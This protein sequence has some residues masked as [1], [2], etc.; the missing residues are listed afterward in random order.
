[1]DVAHKNGVKV[2]GTVFFAP[3]VYGGTQAA[4]QSFLQQDAG[5]NFL[6]AAKM[7]EIANY[8]N[9]DGW[10]MNCE[11]AVNS[12]TGAKMASFMNKLDS[13]YTGELIWYDALLQNGN[14][15]Y[16]NRLNANNAYFFQHSTGLFTNYA[17]TLASTVSSS[18]NYANGLALSPYRVYTGADMWPSRT[19]Q[20]AFTNYTWI[21]KIFNNGI[22][23]TS[24]A[25]FATNFTYN[26]SGFSNFNNDSTDFNNFY[27]AEQQIFS[28]VDRNPFTTD[29]QWKGIGNYIAARST[30]TSL[31]FET[32]FNTGHGLNYYNNG[33]ILLNGSWHN[34]SHQAA[35]PTWTFYNDGINIVYDFGDAFSGGSSLSFTGSASGT[36]NIPLY[37]TKLVTNSNSLNF[38]LALRSISTAIDSIE[39]ELK[40]SDNTSIYSSF[41]PA[42]GGNWEN[43]LNS[44]ISVGASDTI[45]SIGLNFYASGAFAVNIG[46]LGVEANTIATEIDQKANNTICK[47]YPNPSNG[48]FY[49]YSDANEDL[50]KL[51][52][53]DLLGKTVLTKTIKKG[54]IQSIELKSRG[55]YLYEFST[56]KISKQG[57]IIVE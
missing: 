37:S 38:K 54:E 13:A 47:I 22:A 56:G 27:K 40:K 12:S 5:G 34:M 35:L 6:A 33:A 9:F 48:S 24:I 45:V 28:G 14:V 8:Y 16:Q 25:L 41:T 42:F 4:V 10:L 3:A 18:Q 53:T 57:K 36:Y 30:N 23:K 31:P 32:D 46:K 50:G 19:A 29:A 44:N 39:I 7:I 49:F 55:V 17:W 21:D 11:T 43:L 26:Y 1:V 15:T 51:T 2:I 52:I 20:P